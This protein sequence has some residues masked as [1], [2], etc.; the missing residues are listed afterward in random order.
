[1]FGFEIL[2]HLARGA[3]SVL[4][5]AQGTHTNDVHVLKHVSIQTPR[6]KRYYQQLRTE[7]LL[8]RRLGH[9]G[10]RRARSMHIRRS[11]SGGVTEAALILELC[12]GNTLEEYFPTDTTQR[13]CI[14]VRAAMAVAALNDYGYVHCDLKP[15]NIL[16]TADSHAMVIDLG[17]A[18]R[19]GVT[20]ER[21]QGTPN[22]MA[23]EQARRGAMT[24]KTDVFC[25]G[26]TMYT[27]LTGK[28]MPTLMTAG[29]GENSLMID[30]WIPAPHT[31]DASIPPDLSLL[32]M[33]CVRTNMDR[34]PADMHEVVARLSAAGMN[35]VRRVGV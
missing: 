3:G 21:I 5:Y 8:G 30:D 35:E 4:Y 25:F 23:P 22:Y 2:G 28:Q 27:T 7:F 33:D 32:V 24:P 20:K 12:Q 6:D 10:L 26:A 1:L 17:Q 34:R 9:P 11:W 19:I 29:R 16:V 13:I 18:C 31:I 14:F 15:G